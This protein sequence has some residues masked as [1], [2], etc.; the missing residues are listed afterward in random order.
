MINKDAITTGGFFKRGVLFWRT[1]G[2]IGEVD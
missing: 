1:G 2:G